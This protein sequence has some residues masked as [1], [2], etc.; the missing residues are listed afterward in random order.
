MLLVD[1]PDFE[2][3]APASGRVD[4]LHHFERQLGWAVAGDEPPGREPVK[5]S[6]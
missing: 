1:R 6:L 5:Q 3:H 2:F 4:D